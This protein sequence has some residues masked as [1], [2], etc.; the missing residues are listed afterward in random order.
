MAEVA[1][2]LVYRVHQTP[3]EIAKKVNKDVELTKKL[4]KLISTMIKFQHFQLLMFL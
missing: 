2:G 1:L 3:E 4:S